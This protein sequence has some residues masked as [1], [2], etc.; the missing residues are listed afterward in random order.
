MDVLT[1]L[2]E[3]KSAGLRL[4]VNSGKLVIKGP[5]RLD[6]LANHILAHKDAVIAAMAF[7]QLGATTSKLSNSVS[8]GVTET[9]TNHAN[10]VGFADSTCSKRQARLPKPPLVSPTPPQE[11]LADPIVLCPKCHSRRVLLELRT[12]TGGL[13]YPCWEGSH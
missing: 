6:S 5:R 3:A 1:L 12:M 2:N 10:S 9:L 11:I 8:V 4:S 7:P 13:C